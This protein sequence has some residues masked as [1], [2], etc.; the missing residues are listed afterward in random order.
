MIVIFLLDICMTLKAF[1]AFFL[2][3]GVHAPLQGYFLCG[4]CLLALIIANSPKFIRVFTC[5]DLNDFCVIFC[6]CLCAFAALL[7]SAFF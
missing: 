7:I 4:N 2:K 1:Y 6:K 5:F 3:V